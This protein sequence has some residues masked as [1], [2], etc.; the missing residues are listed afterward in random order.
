MITTYTAEGAFI[1]TSC[2]VC[3]IQFGLPKDYESE[4]R[5]DGKGFHCPNKHSLCFDPQGSEEK[6][7][8]CQ[9]A[10]ERARHDQT[11]ANLVDTKRSLIAEKGHRT[12]LK[13]RVANGVCP[14]CNRSFQNLSRHMTTK[15]P[16]YS[17][18]IK[19]G[20]VI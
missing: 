20:E 3:G 19:A 1:T 13:K 4:R 12:R 17:K 18:K 6:K 16:G 8:E 2:C 10:G 15:H 9:L 14:C 11:K 5:R 7:L